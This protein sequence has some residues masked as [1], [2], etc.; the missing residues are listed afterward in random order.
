MGR[1]V[2]RRLLLTIPVLLGASFLIFAMVYALPGDPIAALIGDRRISPAVV[3]ELKERYNLNDPLLVQY[4]KFLGRALHLWN[5]AATAGRRSVT[6]GGCG[7]ARS[8]TSA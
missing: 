2:A 8:S 6:I 4:G 5:P 7:V 1:Y 3:A